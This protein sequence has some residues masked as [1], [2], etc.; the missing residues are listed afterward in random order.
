M[1]IVTLGFLLTTTI[2][3]TAFADDEGC[4]RILARLDGAVRV[5]DNAMANTER[6]VVDSCLLNQSGCS[7]VIDRVS[8]S[9]RALS[10]T[11]HD[12][13][14]WAQYCGDVGVP[15]Q[16]RS[17]LVFQQ[18][19]RTLYRTIE[20]ETSLAISV[21]ARFDTSLEYCRMDGAS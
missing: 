13:S 10:S 2:L 20:L 8:M 17:S 19:E 16:A 12:R 18:W 9:A 6:H 7:Q 11:C 14:D 15:L 21:G 3:G 1:K 5:A 4:A